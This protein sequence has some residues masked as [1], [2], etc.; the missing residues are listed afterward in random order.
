MTMTSTSPVHPQ[1]CP[2]CGQPNQCA[3]EVQLA[4]GIAQPPCWCTQT[5]FSQDLLNKVP[6][7]ARGKAC[8]CAA[9][10]KGANA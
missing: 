9:C 8:V 2:L 3:M 5:Q 6:E 7:A 1:N 10:A 4:T